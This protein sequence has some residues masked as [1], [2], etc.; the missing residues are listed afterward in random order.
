MIWKQGDVHERDERAD[1]ERAKGIIERGH[2]VEERDA[3]AP[4]A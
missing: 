2:V 4:V 3:R 1:Q